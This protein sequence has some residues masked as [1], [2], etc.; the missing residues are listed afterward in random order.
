MSTSGGLLERMFFGFLVAP[1]V[2]VALGTLIGVLF[3]GPI[4]PTGAVI[5]AVL[6]AL[7]GY[8]AEIIFSF[9]LIFFFKRRGQLRNWHYVG[10]GAFG[11]ILTSMP[12]ILLIPSQHP[13]FVTEFVHISAL[14]LP[15][16]LVSGASL[17]W[18]TH[19]RLGA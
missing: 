11:A 12:L 3:F 16:G 17:F 19:R 14:A 18:F 13:S 6:L 15:F 8:A 7:L 2:P 4:D 10:I 1:L 5:L 9:P